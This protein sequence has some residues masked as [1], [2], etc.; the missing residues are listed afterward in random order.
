MAEPFTCSC[1]IRTREP[2]LVNGE[3]LCTICVEQ[4]APRLVSRRAAANW[5]EF[6]YGNRKVPS[7]PSY[8]ARWRDEDD[9]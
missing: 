7:R 3:K 8:R 1:G 5:Q 4:L 9:D 6:T 2:F